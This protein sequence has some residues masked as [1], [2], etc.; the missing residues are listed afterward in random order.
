LQLRE[1]EIL[2]RK[3]SGGTAHLG[4]NIAGGEKG[5]YMTINVTT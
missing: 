3:C 1:N 5:R 2:L 4:G